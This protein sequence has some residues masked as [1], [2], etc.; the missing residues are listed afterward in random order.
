MRTRNSNPIKEQGE[1]VQN[2]RTIWRKIKMAKNKWHQIGKKE[3][4]DIHAKSIIIPILINSTHFHTLPH[5]WNFMNFKNLTSSFWL[6]ETLN[7]KP[8]LSR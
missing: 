4:K 3:E 5:F 1:M 7:K 2:Q 8:I 6:R